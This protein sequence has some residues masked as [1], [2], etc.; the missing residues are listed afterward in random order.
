M[1]TKTITQKENKTLE[2][3]LKELQVIKTQLEKLL[4]FIPEE[5]LKNY[6]NA[7]QI[8]KAFLGAIKKF[9]PK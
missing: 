9:P 7:T 4:I 2:M 3:I 1:D 6:K 5:S 8:K